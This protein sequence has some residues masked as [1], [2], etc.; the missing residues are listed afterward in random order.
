MC[1]ICGI[2][3][4]DNSHVSDSDLLTM[5]TAMKHRGPD[6]EGIFIDDHLG[7]GFVRLSII[8]LT[9]AG[10][11]PMI[12]SDGNYVLIF[13]GEIFNYIELRE[14]LI[15]LG[16]SF[17]TKTDGEVLLQSYLIWGEECLHRFN[18]MWAFAIFDK[19]KNKIFAARDR[20]GIKP[21]YYYSDQNQFVF[22]SEIPPILKVL[23]FK[24]QP[25]ELSVFDYLVFSRT[26][27]NQETFFQDIFRLPHGWKIS[28]SLQGVAESE[29]P[30]TQF[31]EWYDL[32]KQLKAPF[33]SASEFYKSM[34]SAIGLRL[35]SDVPVGVCFSGGLDSSAIISVLLKDFNFLDVN[36]FSSVFQKEQFG[37]ESEFIEL[38]RPLLQNMFYVTPS[39]S[40]LAND[41]TSFVKAHAEPIPS[42]SPYAQF[43]VMELAKGRVVV[44]LDG[45]GADE[46]LAGYHYFYGFY[47]KEL[48]RKL[49]WIK[50]LKEATS[51]MILHRSLYPIKTFIFFLLPG[52]LMSMVRLMEKGYL[53]EGFYKKYL[54]QS[55]VSEDIYSSKG[56]KESLID[57]FKYKL[58][59][60]LKW[61]DRNSM[62]FSIEARVP[63][64]DHQF[65]ER[66]LSMPPGSKIKNGWTK[67]ILRESMK[68]IMPEKVRM[69]KSKVGFG[70]PEAEWFR[71]EPF[72][73]IIMSVI[74][75]QS[76]RDRGI[77]KPEKA[78]SMYMEHLHLKANHSMEI[79]KW[80]N[81]EFWYREFID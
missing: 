54:K 41:L 20:Y 53:E 60:L 11:Q 45:Q 21:L 64:L 77:I 32:E 69:R 6:D 1:G 48:F 65:V 51:C 49:K 43:K 36:T 30:L 70:T 37:D 50:L 26:D 80:I 16:C 74:E 42:T 56:L 72:Q 62:W 63:F 18:G 8:D 34:S 7:L 44:T 15:S 17:Q 28:I 66:T 76:F 52:N 68:G 39:A 35:R 24:A 12:S 29:E 79:W 57:H 10:H 27:H 33:D 9:S 5:M 71:T 81:L 2:I 3:K 47:F 58:E 25:N 61:E 59:H 14:E 31:S 78:K 22:A 55:H 46:L 73:N 19:K 23:N 4:F 38:Y 75:S 40:T 13:N 67:H